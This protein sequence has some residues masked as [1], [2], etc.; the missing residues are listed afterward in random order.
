MHLS[1]D[2]CL[3]GQ[4]LLGVCPSPVVDYGILKLLYQCF[5]E[6]PFGLL[7]SACFLS[8]LSFGIGVLNNCRILILV[9]L[10]EAGFGATITR[11]LQWT[12]SSLFDQWKHWCIKQNSYGF[13][14]M[15]PDIG[16][17]PDVN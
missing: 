6:L 14:R 7:V 8:S 16:L 5:S 15:Y 17:M 10:L 2:V 13:R 11:H 1:I 4:P 3:G 12:F 9:G